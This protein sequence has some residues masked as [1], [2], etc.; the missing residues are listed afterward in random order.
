MLLANRRGLGFAAPFRLALRAIA[1]APSLDVRF[2]WLPPHG[3]RAQA[4]LPLQA[5]QRWRLKVEIKVHLDD[6]AHLAK[7]EQRG[8][9]RDV[10]DF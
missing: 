2:C 9:D 10:L 7:C 3:A 6:A 5:R 8:S 1:Q 4:Q